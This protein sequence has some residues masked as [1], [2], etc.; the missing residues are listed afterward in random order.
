MMPVRLPRICVAVSG[1]DVAELLHNAELAVREDKFLEFRLDYLKQPATALPKLR[2]FVE[3]HPETMLIATCRRQLNGGMFRGSVASEIEMLL[4][5]AAAG[6]QI[7]DI[8]IE[9]AQAMKS[10]EL[11]KVRS[12]AALLLSF[13]D[14]KAT[15]KLEE[16][17]QKMIAIPADHYKVATTATKLYDNVVM[18]KFLEEKSQE[19]SVVGLCM[20]EQ[21]I[22]SRVLGLRAGSAFTF[23]APGKGAETAPGQLSAHKLRELYRIDQLDAATKV[24][25]VVGNPV[26]QSLSPAMLNAAFRRENVNALYL[27]L[28]ARTID[29]LLNCVRDIPIHG[30]SVTMPY[31]EE[32]VPHLDNT[33]VLTQRTGACNTVVRGQDGRLFGFNT[34]VGGVVGPLE[35]RLALRR[36][37]VLVIGAGGAARAA[38]FGLKARGAEVF[39]INRTPASGQKLARQAEAK[40]LKRTDLKKYEFDV[41][42]N[43]TPLGMEN[44]T[45]P[46]AENEIKARF[47]FDMVYTSQETPFCKAAKAAGVDVIPG[48]EMFVQQGA[49][50]FEMWTGKPAPETEMQHV[51]TAALA[52]REAKKQATTLAAREAR[53]TAAPR[54]G[55]KS[56]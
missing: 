49:R 15:R 43:A 9:T 24:Y 23:A 42:I 26:S 35:R 6:F 12:K 21:G 33:D 38:V 53:K 11:Q 3:M 44:K 52:A 18:M 13:H 16:T 7:L 45:S 56:S 50:Q 39:I 2:R 31:K 36:S 19:H 30:L 1:A 25:G 46:L 14:F 5:A 48:Y 17:F 22:I 4:K 40:Y 20:G 27:A 8:E 34:D 47:A 55:H 51:V 41:I 37:R 32:I 10:A 28:H 29:D 54:N